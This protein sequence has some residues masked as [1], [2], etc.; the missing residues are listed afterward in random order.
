MRRVSAVGRGYPNRAYAKWLVLHFAWKEFGGKIQR[1]S[2]FREAC[3]RPKR[4]A[5]L[6]K[7]IDR[8]I[9]ALFKAALEF[10]RHERGQGARALDIS[11]FFYQKGRHTSFEKFWNRRGYGHRKH[12]DEQRDRFLEL[13]AVPFST[14]A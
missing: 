2:P 7:P 5:D 13:L 14:A 6:L 8:A 1:S 3:E 9:E 11:N 4:H 12:F 10:Y